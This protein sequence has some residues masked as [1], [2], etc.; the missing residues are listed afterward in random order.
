MHAKQA[1]TREATYA[2]MRFMLGALFVCHGA[3]KLWG[4]F[5]GPAAD[6]PLMIAGG[7]IEFFGGILIAV[8]LLTR[9]AAFL[10]SGEMAVA[11]FMS[12]AAKGFWPIVNGGE[13]AILYCF[14]FLFIAAYG[15]GIYSLDAVVRRANAVPEDTGVPRHV[16]AASSR[17]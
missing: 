4:A 13:K 6:K 5:G 17:V 14:P 8:G 11:Y 12:H 2:L 9:A 1:R 10:A 15:G 16:T 3:Q 7:V